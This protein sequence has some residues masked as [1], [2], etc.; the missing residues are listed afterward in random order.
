MKIA[1]SAAAV[2]AL[3]LTLSASAQIPAP[4]GMPACGGVRVDQPAYNHF[5]LRP[6]SQD[7]GFLARRTDLCSEYSH[8][9]WKD[10]MR[11]YL[12]EGA[13][14]HREI[15]ELAVEKWN[16]ALMGFNQEPI[17]EITNRRPRNYSLPNDFWATD[18]DNDYSNDYSTALVDDKQSVIYFKGGGGEWRN[19]GFARWRWS[20]DNSTAESDMYINVTDWDDVGPHLVR[21][22]ELLE[23]DGYHSYAAVDS[24]YL[25][26][27]HEIGHALGLYHVPV[28]GNIMSYNYMPYMKDLWSVPSTLELFRK[29]EQLGSTSRVFDSSRSSP[30][31]SAFAYRGPATYLHAY[32]TDPDSEMK[33][34]INFFT[35]SA[36]IG[37]Q[38]R[39]ALLCIYEF[40]RWNH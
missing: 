16:E 12:G 10:T 25:V 14:R 17:I 1:R 4:G 31:I 21:L 19:G 20:D 35:Q 26:V 32:Y 9:G 34:M 38:D 30:I 15:L 36:G 11:L 33:A 13:H 22:Q 37:E 29:T 27:L 18:W 8:S 6:R 23:I 28:S 5:P 39:M 2:S 40:S 3:A 24:L 7:L